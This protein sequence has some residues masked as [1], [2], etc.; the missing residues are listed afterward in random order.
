VYD[1]GSCASHCNGGCV[2]G[3]CGVVL[4]SGQDFPSAIAVDAKSVYWTS[5][6]GLLKVPLQGG[7]EAPVAIS[8]GNAWSISLRDG[9]A[10]WVG[11]F[12]ERVS[13]ADGT[14]TRLGRGGSPSTLAMATDDANVYWPSGDEIFKVPIQGGTVHALATGQHEPLGIA[15]DATNVYWTTGS[16]GTVMK[17]P[18]G[19]GTPTVLAQDQ[20]FTWSVAA[21]GA[22]VY[23]TSTDGTGSL[24][25]MP[26][27]GGPITTLAE[28]VDL[29]YGFALDGGNVYWI[30]T[31]VYKVS[32][33]GGPVT[34]LAKCVDDDVVGIAVDETSV[35]FTRMSEGTV[36]RVTPK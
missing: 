32:V 28:H 16:A 3:H 26:V 17:V 23:W 24:V 12:V 21:D 7:A 25:K 5:N 2:S 29:A 34:T 19:G 4:A 9:Y 31:G 14:I 33:A 30:D 11:E 36:T 22:Y 35:Y 18:I 15:V 1:D 8:A 10:Y 6:A 20:G 27:Q 13:I